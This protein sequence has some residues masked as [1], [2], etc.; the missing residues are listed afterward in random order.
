MIR[1]AFAWDAETNLQYFV[2][3]DD[4]VIA[5]QI[6]ATL[7]QRRHECPAS[8]VF[9]MNDAVM[10]L[11]AFASGTAKGS[12][13]GEVDQDYVV[14]VV[15]VPD[16]EKALSVMREIRRRTTARVLAVGPATD[17]KLVLR[18][19]REGAG[20]YLDVAELQ[21]ELSEALQ[22]L[23][24]SGNSGRTIV[25]LA[26]SGGS[27]ASTLAVNV[28]TTL[29]LKYHRCALIDLKLE[30]GDLASLLD[31]KPK[32]T[33][34]DLCQNIVRLD[35]SLLQG[36]LAPCDSGVQLLAAPERLA[37]VPLV[38]P[39]AVDLILSLVSRHF[40]FVVIDLDHS[41][42]PEQR[43]AMLLADV[44]VLI[45]RLDF[46]SLRKTR[47]TLEFFQEIGVPR[48]KVRIVANR[49]GELNQLTIAQAEGSLGI[50]ISQL[51]PEDPKSVNRANNNGVP[52]V[53]ESPSAKVSR[54]LGELAASLVG[55]I[56]PSG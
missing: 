12:A 26:P 42:R 19:L 11:E 16:P 43:R 27:G 55:P 37:D 49:V 48:E 15:L 32:H 53:Q 4:A 31:L 50:K 17:T 54:S 41:F 30:A 3:S 24:S 47:I 10:A 18:A 8:H 7:V 22:R 20:E 14:L 46:I 1:D 25:M 34:S 9:R 38:T 21:S 52:V 39:E 28:A 40:P 36:C 51:I 56:K 23:E 2:T 35:Y 33:L 45:L 13:I 44:I 29:A 6:S 5:N